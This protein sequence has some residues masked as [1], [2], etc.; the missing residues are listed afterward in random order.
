MHKTIG[1][2]ARF[3]VIHAGSIEGFVENL[4]PKIVYKNEI[5][6][7][8]FEE[9]LE[10]ELMPKLP[11]NSL[12]I[13]DNCS[14]HSRQYNKTPTMSSNKTT[15][16]EWLINNNIYFDEYLG[17]KQLIEIVK[18]NPKPPQYYVDDIVKKFNCHPLRLPPY[19]C[20]LNPIEMI[21]NTWK[22]D[23]SHHNFNSNLKEFK[24]LLLKCFDSIS[25]SVWGNT[26]RKMIR[27]VESKYCTQ[28]NIFNTPN[29]C[30]HN[31]FF[32]CNYY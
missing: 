21:W 16:K 1:K 28:F 20:D 3:A 5:N 2:G 22:Q 6:S 9:W 14:V 11:E 12:V 18:N 17:K 32:N 29:N 30:E 10:K 7:E 15:I 27:D 23:V 25:S 13:Y 26:V 19:M 24:K 4:K 31:Y 8:I